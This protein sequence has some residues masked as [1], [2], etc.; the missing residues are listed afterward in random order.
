MNQTPYSYMPNP[1]MINGMQPSN[2]ESIAELEQRVSRL[3]RQVKRLE[4]KVFHNENINQ[5]DYSASPP[6]DKGMYMM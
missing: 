1:Y 3:E 4:H 6:K 5:N 2:M